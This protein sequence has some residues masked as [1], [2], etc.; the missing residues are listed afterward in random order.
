VLV[1]VDAALAL[2]SIA[3][4]ALDSIGAVYLD[5]EIGLWVL[6]T[7]FDTIAVTRAHTRSTGDTLSFRLRARG[8]RGGFLYSAEVLE[9]ETE[10]GGRAR[11]AVEGLSPTTHVAVSDP[12]LARAFGALP[13][14][15]GRDDPALAPLT[16]LVLTRGDTV[17]LYAEAHGLRAVGAEAHYRVELTIRRGDRASLPARVVS[18]LGRR[19]G[20]GGPDVPPRLAW[21]ATAPSSSPG[22]IAVDL[23]LEGVDAG[24]Q[25]IE[26]RVTD[27]TTG[28]RAVSRRLVRIVE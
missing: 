12:L 28:E 7:A 3:E 1:Q 13:P 14:P 25:V 27:V 8:P 9:T 18:W 16:D 5:A 4:Q 24:L 19:L 2:D 20:L 26:V 15:T 23:Q 11:Y 10:L 17:G 6:D 21:S 22:I